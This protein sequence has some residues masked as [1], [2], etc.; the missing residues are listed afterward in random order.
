[1]KHSGVSVFGGPDDP[2]P[3]PVRRNAR[4]CAR[5]D[6]L[7]CR[8]RNRRLDKPCV[9]KAKLQNGIINRRAIKPAAEIR[10]RA[11]VKSPLQWLIEFLIDV[12]I[13][14]WV[15]LTHGVTVGKI[16]VSVLPYSNH[17]AP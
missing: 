1:M 12:L 8:V 11:A 7:R 4:D 5:I 16:K 14:H 10:W 3:R 2:V 17:Q 13:S 9:D 15:E 6:K